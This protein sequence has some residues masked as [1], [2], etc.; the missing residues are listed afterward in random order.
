MCAATDVIN[1]ELV[2]YGSG[3]NGGA[4]VEIGGSLSIQSTEGGE[5][6]IT[7]RATGSSSNGGLLE[8]GT[9]IIIAGGI[10]DAFVSADQS[11]FIIDNGGL[12]VYTMDA[13][14]LNEVLKIIQVLRHNS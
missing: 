10:G 11:L 6:G 8:I 2:I 13:F 14:L 3:A 4:E 7:M 9:G 12:V 5:A 1:A